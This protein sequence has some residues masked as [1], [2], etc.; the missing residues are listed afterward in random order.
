MMNTTAITAATGS[1]S[2]E[3]GSTSAYRQYYATYQGDGLTI[4]GRINIP[5]GQGPFPAVVLAHGYVPLEEYTNG[6]TTMRSTSVVS[7]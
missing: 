5:R 4:S 1:G 2:R 6:A 7:P 3:S